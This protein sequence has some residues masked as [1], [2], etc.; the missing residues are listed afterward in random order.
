MEEEAYD[1]ESD[2]WSK[3]D[4]SLKVLIRKLLCPDENERI[5]AKEA[6]NSEWLKKMLV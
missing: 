4:P 3:F 1:L 2:N 5:T 6:K